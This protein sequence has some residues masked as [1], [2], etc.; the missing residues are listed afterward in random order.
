MFQQASCEP[1]A[2]LSA[3]VISLTESHLIQ[4]S[5]NNTFRGSCELPDEK[6]ERNCA[7]KAQRVFFAVL[8]EQS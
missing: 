7:K 5:H 2:A 4:R 6:W 8:T 1:E 3:L